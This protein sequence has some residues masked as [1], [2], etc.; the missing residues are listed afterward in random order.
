[1]KNAPIYTFVK[2]YAK[3][4]PIRLH[5]PGHKGKRLLGPEPWDI[6]E[7]AGADTLYNANG[8][9]RQSE[10]Y[11]SVLF[12]SQRTLYSTEGSSH[13]IR[14][15]LYLVRLYAAS[16]KREPRLLC[17]R[18]AHKALL[19]AAALV[20]IK[21][22]WLLG[23]GG[24]LSYTPDPSALEEQLQRERP[25]ALFVTSPDYLGNTLDIGALASLCHRYGTLLL[26]DNAHGAY[27]RFLSPS[28]H[29]LDGGCDLCCDSAHKTLPALTGAAYLHIGQNAPLFLSQEAEGAMALFA[30]TSPS[31]LTLAS[32]DRLNEHLFR[33]FPRA[34]EALLP[35]LKELRESLTAHGYGLVGDEPLKLTL[36]TK[37]LGYSGS[38]LAS[39]LE[40][41][42][43]LVE[44]ADPDHVVLMLSPRLSGRELSRVERVL[45]SIPRG[46]PIE[47]SAPPAVSGEA[48][49]SPREA[50]MRPSTAVP[51][52][53]AEGKILGG[54]PTACPPAVPILMPG[55]RIT[56]EAIEAFRYY[57]YQEITVLCDE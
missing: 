4:R 27:L 36:L 40:R 29:P 45:L 32:L 5:M 28:R 46:R 7:I 47:Q 8:V 42:R 49:L 43:I 31:Y 57:G 21:V 9:I 56:P 17:A 1:M 14:A 39:L 12:G 54:L 52:E 30:S 15:M 26:V 6:T 53:W 33:R 37:P 50:L 13:C 35:R 51:L 3:R 34:L 11:A 48:V 24:L 44:H 38:T 10:R 20:D 41:K 2:R 16:Q 55:E 23:E 25:I 22:T 18:N 19:S